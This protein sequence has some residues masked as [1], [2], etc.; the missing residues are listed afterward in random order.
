MVNLGKNLTSAQGISLYGV[1]VC[2]FLHFFFH[3]CF[4]FVSVLLIAQ[5]YTGIVTGSIR[6]HQ[7]FSAQSMTL[8]VFSASCS[9]VS[10]KAP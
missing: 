3:A 2:L 1:L 6:G 5:T 4:V 10:G 7:I 8:D 9:K